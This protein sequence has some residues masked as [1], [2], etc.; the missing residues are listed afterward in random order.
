[1][2]TSLVGEMGGILPVKKPADLALNTGFRELSHNMNA[3]VAIGKLN[4]CFREN[5]GCEAELRHVEYMSAELD[6]F[7]RVIRKM[8]CRCCK[9][10]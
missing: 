5:D 3:G 1:M 9:N 6:D 4:G 7:I 2:L 8:A 10:A